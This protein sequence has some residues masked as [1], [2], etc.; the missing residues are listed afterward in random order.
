MLNT[1]LFAKKPRFEYETVGSVSA[2]AETLPVPDKATFFL[3]KPLDGKT[4]LTLKV[5]DR[6]KTGQKISPF[7]EADVCA[8]SSVTGTVASITPYTGDYG[9]VYT[10]ISVAA[11]EKDDF[12]GTFGEV[13]NEEGVEAVRDYLACIP[14]APSLELLSSPDQAID[15]IVVCGVEKD[16]L[17]ATNQHVLKSNVAFMNA[18]ISALKKMTGAHKIVI[19]LPQGLMADAGGIGGASGAELR[20][21]DTVYPASLPR[22]IMKDIIGKPVPADK[23]CEDLGVCFVSAEAA[24][25]VGRAVQERQMPVMKSFTLIDKNLGKRM[26]SARI[27]TPVSSVF[28]AFDISLYDK[29]RIIMGGPMTGAAIFSEDHPIGPD[30]DAL[31]VQAGADV[32]EVANTPCINCGECVRICPADIPVNML[33][34]FLEARQYEDAAEMYDLYSCVECGLCSFVCVSK[35]PIFQYIRLAKYELDRIRKEEEAADV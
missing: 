5:G 9:Q 25:A 20:V 6:V 17:V 34:R 29:D 10:A 2:E 32:P 14:G 24:A 7:P 30:T 21:I 1:S 33:V 3:K 4:A 28:S 15:T 31:M 27:G 19:A 22:M 16:L 8:I 13:I 26:V 23:S 12:D 18:G 11:D 35:I